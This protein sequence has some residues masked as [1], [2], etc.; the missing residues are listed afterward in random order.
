[1]RVEQSPIVAAECHCRSCRTAAV[2]MRQLGCLSTL[3]AN[4]GTQYVLYRKDRVVF[5]QGAEQLRA[6]RLGPQAHTRRVVAACCKTPMFLEFDEGHWLSIYARRWDEARR[7]SMELRTM[8][9]D[10]PP[11]TELSADVPN[12][13]THSF[14]FYRKLMGAWIRMGFRAPKLAIGRAGLESD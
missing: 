8:T 5:E 6:H 11:G 13:A 1:M 14:S 2:Q 12:Y 4:G 9:S 10:V 3:E 7:P